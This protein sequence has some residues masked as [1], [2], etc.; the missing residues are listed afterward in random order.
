MLLSRS[1]QITYNGSGSSYGPAGGLRRTTGRAAPYASPVVP[2]SMSG[3]NGSSSGAP[4]ST[5]GDA[6]TVDQWLAHQPTTAQGF[7]DVGYL[8]TYGLLK[9]SFERTMYVKG[10]EKDLKLSRD[11]ELYRVE[12]INV[13]E[14][15]RFDSLFKKMVRVFEEKSWDFPAGVK[16][17]WQDIKKDT[18]LAPHMNL[19]RFSQA[20]AGWRKKR[21]TVGHPLA[22]TVSIDVSVSRA[23]GISPEKPDM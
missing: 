2:P 15:E 1:I 12:K 18:S 6:A 10:I 16:H 5:Q 20:A 19:Q 9:Q 7:L 4:S 14:V 8:T 17:D 3:S 21:Q 13:T 23:F 11:F 22:G